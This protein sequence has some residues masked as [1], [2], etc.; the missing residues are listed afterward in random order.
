MTD[1]KFKIF[2]LAAVMLA[3]AAPMQAKTAWVDSQEGIGVYYAL[4]ASDKIARVVNY[5]PG[6]TK[7]KLTIPS[8]IKVDKVTYTVTKIGEEAF[9]MADFTT[10]NLP[11]TITL[12]GK[13][14]FR[15]SE[16]KNVNIPTSVETIQEEAFKGTYI[17]SV[18]IPATCSTIGD[19]AF[20]GARIKTLTFAE[21]NRTK[22]K[23]GAWAFASNL[24][25]MVNVPYNVTSLGEGAFSDNNIATVGWHTT[26]TTIPAYCFMR[27]R[28]LQSVDLP[29]GIT[30]I[31]QYAFAE[32]GDLTSVSLP[33]SLVTLGDYCFWRTG[34]GSIYVHEGVV[35]LGNSVFNSCPFL[36]R[37]YL[38]STLKTIGETCFSSS[39][40]I[41]FISCE[42]TV[43]PLCGSSVFSNVTFT[44]ADLDVP[45]S[46]WQL[47]KEA[48]T[49]CS[50]NFDRYAG[51]GEVP[52]DSTESATPI[53]YDLNGNHIAKP[54]SGVCIEVRGVKARKV[55]F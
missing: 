20:H 4:N 39:D 5:D 30:S 8:T 35:S 11:N 7:K 38:P 55:I 52:D 28:K 48:D 25:T 19:Y 26:A 9:S 12:I 41:E 32:C 17:T 44:R 46:V 49:W 23:I 40:Q 36:S 42:A 13:K 3:G 29:L 14:A 24:L 43:P 10:I 33:G 53:Y 6:T 22:L 21:T 16:L 54:E 37:V 18:A 31:G 1:T 47:Y 15:H 2:S 51:V 50:F 27:C 34:L 45:Q